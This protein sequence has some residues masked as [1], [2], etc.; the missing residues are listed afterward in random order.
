MEFKK[1]LLRET[2]Q[3]DSNGVKTYSENPQ[4]IIL[5]ENQ[6]ERLIENLNGK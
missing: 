2:L 1:K 6:L 5:T 4:N 3:I